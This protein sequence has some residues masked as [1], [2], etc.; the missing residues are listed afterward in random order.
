MKHIKTY[1]GWND[2]NEGW[3]EN[4]ITSLTLA[5]SVAFG[6]PKIETDF[7]KGYSSELVIEDKDK[8]FYSACFQA[9]QEM[10]SGDLNIEQSAALLEAQ[11]YFQSKRDNEKV[12]KL[13]DEGKIATKIVMEKVMS[14][15]K[16]E[17]QRLIDSGSNGKVSGHIVGL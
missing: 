8:D 5:S 13:S 14:L 12:V 16:D 17:I 6:S 2:V 11:M 3:K 15:P 9:C 10:K 1:K 4:L 7:N